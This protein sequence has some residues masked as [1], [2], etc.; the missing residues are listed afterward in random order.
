VSTRR[1]VVQSGRYATD[2]TGAKLPE[3]S[4]AEDDERALLPMNRACL[5]LQNVADEPVVFEVTPK[6]SKKSRAAK[7]GE[8]AGDA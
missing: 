5:T 8:G 7:M 6:A 2:A 1:W 4:F 3:R